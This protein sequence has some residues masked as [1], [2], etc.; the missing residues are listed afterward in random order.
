MKAYFGYDA[1]L[2]TLAQFSLFNW[3][4][5]GAFFPP[6]FAG[7][8]PLASS[9]LW[10][11]RLFWLRSLSLFSAL[12]LVRWWLCDLNVLRGQWIW[13][14]RL[15]AAC[16]PCRFLLGS[17]CYRRSNKPP[18]NLLVPTVSIW[19][20]YP[21]QST[22]AAPP[23]RVWCGAI[24]SLVLCCTQPATS[25][26]KCDFKCLECESLISWFNNLPQ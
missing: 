7:D 15:L 18:G 1:W 25:D 10:A 5:V 14:L 19:D 16:C 6:E 24:H 17:V 9:G 2:L 3:F 11:M 4:A 26:F 12:L 20:I 22:G 13:L 21:A 23:W 8:D